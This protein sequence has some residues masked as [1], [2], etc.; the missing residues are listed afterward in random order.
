MAKLKKLRIILPILLVLIMAISMFPTVPVY[1]DS[2]DLYWKGGSGNWSD[3]THWATI[4]TTGT[5]DFVNG[6][7]TVEGAGGCSWTGLTGYIR[8]ATSGTWYTISS[9]TDSDTLEMTG[10]FA[11]SST[12]AVSYVIAKTGHAIPTSTNNVYF[13]IGSGT[14]SYTVSQNE[15]IA[16]CHDFTIVNPSS[17]VASFGGAGYLILKI[18][19]SLSVG[20]GVTWSSNSGIQFYATTSET[21]TTNGVTLMSSGGN[22]TMIFYGVGGSW[23]L[24]DSL[25]VGTSTSNLTIWNGSLDT[26]GKT[27]TIAGNMHNDQSGTSALT[28]G[29]STVNVGGDWIG[30]QLDT[31][32][33]DTSTINVAG[34]DFIG[35]GKTYYNVNISGTTKT[36]TGANTFNNL[37]L[38]GTST[39]DDEVGIGANQT[40]TGTFTTTGYSASRR[41]LVKS[42]T[43]HTAR[44]ITA[45]TVSASNTLFR[46]ITGAGAGSWDLSSSTGVGDCCGNTGITFPTGISVYAVD[47]I[48]NGNFSDSTKWSST[49]NGTGGTGR[50]PLP[51]DTAIFDDHS[52][53]INGVIITFDTSHISGLNTVYTTRNP[54]FTG[55]IAY[56]YNSINLGT[57]IWDVQTSFY[58]LGDGAQ[59]LSGDF[60]YGTD[61]LYIDT[62]GGSITQIGDLTVAGTIYMQSGVWDTGEY[63]ITA[64]VF[65]SATTTYTRALWMVNTDFTLTSTG[66]KWNVAST[67]LNID[68]AGSEIIL[69]NSTSTACTFAG[70]GMTYN[71]LTIEG[72][73]NY[74]TTLTGANVFHTLTIDRTQA[75]KTLAGAVTAT[76]DHMYI[77]VYG[78][79]T[80]T[81]TDTDFSK[82]TGLVA[83]DYLILTNSA[84]SGGAT[85][86]AG[87]HS[88]DTQGSTIVT[89]G[90]MET[91]VSASQLTNWTTPFGGTNAVAR[92]TDK[93]AGTYAAQFTGGSTDPRM[94]RQSMSLVSGT[95]YTITAWIK[96]VSG[97]TTVNWRFADLNSSSNSTI[98]TSWAQYTF[99]VTYSGTSGSKTVDLNNGTV[100]SVLLIDSVSI[101]SSSN[102]GWSFTDATAPTVSAAA[103]SLTT[104]TTANLN[105]SLD[106]LGSYTSDGVYIYFIY[107]TVAITSL[108]QSTATTTTPDHYTT[109]GTKSEGITGLTLNT[110]YYYKMV[111]VYNSTSTVYTDDTTFLTLGAPTVTTLAVP[112][113][114]IEDTTATLYGELLSFGDYASVYGFFLVGTKTQD[115]D[116]GGTFPRTAFNSPDV[117][118]FHFDMTGLTSGVTYYV[119]AAVLYNDVQYAYGT[120]VSFTTVEA[121]YIGG[122]GSTSILG[123]NPLMPVQMYTELDVSKVPGGDAINDILNDAGL[124]TTA[125]KG[126]WWFPFIFGFIGILA[127][128]VYG[129]TV[130]TGGQGSELL[131]CIVIEAGLIF[132]GILGATNTSSLIPL[133]PMF[134]FPLPAIALIFSKKHYGWG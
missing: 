133:W 111:C 55:T 70:G 58:M 53:Q 112:T 127:L 32:T 14:T 131:M 30:T 91:W 125:S 100:S 13:N 49:S 75:A 122:G 61:N 69:T 9:I 93:I 34:D 19:G 16:Y 39:A 119:K 62:Q 68:Y 27:L 77:P 23:Q 45:A 110:T 87:S 116:L 78:T 90:G 26:N 48:G 86:L 106:N 124:T 67:N 46:D 132:F 5:A 95:T 123:D 101:T 129:L 118:T 74:S 40:I 85:Y 79:N 134:L 128:L 81:I 117:G 47:W 94:A 82:T 11:E 103:A 76:I 38:T 51:Q 41:L 120:E 83:S 28:L 130:K 1:A 102:S 2:V 12:G 105:G 10:T 4:Y 31:L 66:T 126:L 71:D 89:D 3:T 43:L 20:S 56:F 65:D 97:G 57:C 64:Y 73:G 29:A 80:V 60:S 114:T 25:T 33:A 84:A 22:P 115:Y 52:M 44:T 72:S 113:S 7:A 99:T 54:Q 6:D 88:T 104:R 15:S 109:T 121:P 59:T 18:Y 92:S 21:I 96:S 63:D 8:V 42:G 98:T 107:D 108:T 37:T 36:I 50:V 35:A 17:G 24:Q